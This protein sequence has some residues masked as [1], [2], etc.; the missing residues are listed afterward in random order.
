MGRCAGK[1]VPA[2]RLADA[3]GRPVGSRG[4]DDRWL[5]GG[6]EVGLV[7]ERFEVR[8]LTS[9][10]AI[11]A[12]QGDRTAK[13]LERGRR[14]AALS[15]GRRHHVVRVIVT[16]IFLQRALQ[17][18]HRRRDVAGIL[19]DGRGVDP[20]V[21]RLRGWFLGL[22]FPLADFEIQPGAFQ[23]LPFVRIALDHIAQRGGRGGKI[24]ALQSLQASFVHRD[25]LVIGR[26]ARRWR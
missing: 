6:T 13:V 5:E 15:A 8:I 7:A 1:S 21:G 3:R 19:G 23:Q 17:M 24:A 2:A 22:Q 11:L 10:G 9:A 14:I 26:L 18:P 25:R 20:L 12:V 16:G 4:L